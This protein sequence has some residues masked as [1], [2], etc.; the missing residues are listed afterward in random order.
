ML[1]PDYASPEQIAGLAVGTRSDVYSLGVLLF[2]LLTGARPYRLKRDTRAALE[3][4][5]LA[6]EV[7]R[8]S[9]AV[10]EPALRR[11]L[12]GDLDTIVLKALKKP[13]AERYASVEAMAEDIERHLS[14]RPVLARPDSAWYRGR[15][16]IVR[17][18]L[19]VG[20]AAALLLTVLGRR[21]RGAL[22]GAHRG[23]G[24]PACR[25][26]EGFRRR[27]LPRGQPVRRAAARRRSPRSIC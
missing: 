5:I 25:G 17:N 1:T 19:A 26:R 6:A 12:R 22:A 8:P 21:R 27:H 11:A 13:V 18:R 23:G 14:M 20:T 4:A 16:F 10:A 7:P 9:D 2:E 24:A 15:K 3:E